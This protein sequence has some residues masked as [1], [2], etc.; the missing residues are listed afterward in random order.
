VPA[1]CHPIFNV[2]MFTLLDVSITL[3]DMHWTLV[4]IW[5]VVQNFYVLDVYTVQIQH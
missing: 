3:L 5:I 2:V 4:N 1:S